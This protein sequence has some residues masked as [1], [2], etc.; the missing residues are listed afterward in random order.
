[1]KNVK[2]TVDP[3]AMAIARRVRKKLERDFPMN[4]TLKRLCVVASTTLHR[5]LRRHGFKP[6]LAGNS[7]HVFVILD[8]MI[9]DIT[10][11]Q[12]DKPTPVTTWPVKRRWKHLYWTIT[13]EE[14]TVH[15]MMRWSEAVGWPEQQL[16]KTRTST[17]KTIRTF[18]RKAY[19]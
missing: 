10:A 16:P 8:G 9:I 11:T 13:F 7:N 6:T 12:F 1:M 3:R 19:P 18:L 15:Q 2:P 17:R 4:P 5:W 14:P